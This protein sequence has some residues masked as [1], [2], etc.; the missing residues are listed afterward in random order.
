MNST[1]LI[2]IVHAGC[3][4]TKDAHFISHLTIVTT[5]VSTPRLLRGRNIIVS[6]LFF[7][8]LFPDIRA[9]SRH[10]IK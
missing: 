8:A 9:T 1:P 10:L 4:Q 7:T 2:V 3:T 5:F 6:V